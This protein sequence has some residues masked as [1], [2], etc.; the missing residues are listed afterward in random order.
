MN[1][2]KRTLKSLGAIGAA[3]WLSFVSQAA[4]AGPI[5]IGNDPVDR[6]S[7]DSWRN[8]VI[9]LTT[10]VFPV[11]GQVTEWSIYAATAGSMALLIMDNGTVVSTDV[12]EVTE[13][14]NTFTFSATTGDSLIQTGYNVGLW[15][16]T[17][18]VDFSRYAG[19]AHGDPS[20]YDTVQWCLSNGCAA[21]A[22]IA[23]DFFTF[24]G[25]ETANSMRQYSVSVV[26]PPL[27]ATTVP[28]PGALALLGLG[29]FGFGVRRRQA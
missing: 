21:S 11:D 23:G 19:D 29:L 2:N 7:S 28:T 6:E 22:P 14:F 8:F 3:M 16:G 26:D 25:A 9:D 5:T 4:L 24:T 1:V 20:Q 13:G 15:M 12:R 18:T 27:V 17:G 10:E